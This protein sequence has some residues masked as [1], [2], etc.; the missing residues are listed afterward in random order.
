MNLA[1]AGGACRRMNCDVSQ[2][3]ELAPSY[4]QHQSR[5]CRRQIMPALRRQGLVSARRKLVDSVDHRVRGRSKK[6][7]TP[8][9]PIGRPPRH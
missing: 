2:E 1:L 8:M 7:V 9:A 3:G 6:D 5:V 4:L